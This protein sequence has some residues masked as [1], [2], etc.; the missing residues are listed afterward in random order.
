MNA[1]DSEAQQYDSCEVFTFTT[2][3]EVYRYTSYEEDLTIGGF[4]F[5]AVPIKRSG[6]N[7]DL[8]GQSISINIQ[9][10]VTSVFA[11][12]LVLMPFIP[13]TFLI[14]KYYFDDFTSSQLVFS[15]EVRSLTVGKQVIN[16]E[17]VSSSQELDR[18]L[19][20]FLT[21]SY[22]NN[23]LGDS[24]CGIDLTNAL[25]TSHINVDS[26]DE[27]DNSIIYSAVLTAFSENR[28]V[29]GKAIFNND[30]RLITEQN[31]AQGYI[32]LHSPIIELRVGDSLQVTVYCDK[33]PEQCYFIFGNMDN[34]T[35]MA[36]VPKGTNPT[37][38]GVE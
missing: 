35:G 15:G 5:Q 12:Y 24:V 17:C 38:F 20:R 25:Y 28:L 13:I 31:K 4:T 32:R 27:E 30:A 6:F 9:L 19:P 23:T 8:Q 37:I 3:N 7:K 34:F 36:Y 18:K 14:Q 11:E 1:H 26:I 2:E 29:L 22:C 16:A 10:P 33:S 21:H